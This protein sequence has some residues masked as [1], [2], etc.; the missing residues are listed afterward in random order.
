MSNLGLQRHYTETTPSQAHT[1]LNLRDHSQLSFDLVCT[2]PSQDSDGVAPVTRFHVL[3]YCGNHPVGAR[4]FFPPLIQVLFFVLCSFIA[5]HYP[6]W[7]FGMG[8]KSF[9]WEFFFH[10]FLEHVLTKQIF[11][12]FLHI[13]GRARVGSS[14]R[15]VCPLWISLCER[16]ASQ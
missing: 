2:W 16:I 6:L 8:G 14:F 10:K 7:T 5:L 13:L 9:F 1:S 15:V 3:L 4:D 12:S 11:L